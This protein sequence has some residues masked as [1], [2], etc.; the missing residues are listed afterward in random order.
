MTVAFRIWCETEARACRSGKMMISSHG[1]ANEAL[2]A[3][4]LVF[5]RTREEYSAKVKE[6]EEARSWFPEDSTKESRL[7][8]KATNEPLKCAVCGEA[9]LASPI[10]E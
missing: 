2:L 7:I 4:P 9:L 5:A 8:S 3:Y 10:P 1:P 6:V